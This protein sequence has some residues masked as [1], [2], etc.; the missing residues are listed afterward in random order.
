MMAALRAKARQVVAVQGLLQLLQSGTGGRLQEEA[1]QA[2]A[3]L[4]LL[5][6]CHHRLGCHLAAS[7]LQAVVAVQGPAVVAGVHVA[8]G[9][10][11]GVLPRA[12]PQM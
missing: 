2:A 8:A 7:Q 4:L 6:P 12:P 9:M 1:V 3:L 10:A 11:R 5:L